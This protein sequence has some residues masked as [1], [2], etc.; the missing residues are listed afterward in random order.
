MKFVKKQNLKRKENLTNKK[1]I[2]INRESVAVETGCG[3]VKP[4]N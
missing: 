3:I 1:S 2:A 4:F